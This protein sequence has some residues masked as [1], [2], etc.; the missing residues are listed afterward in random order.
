M[1]KLKKITTEYVSGNINGINVMRDNSSVITTY[2]IPRALY[3]EANELSKGKYRGLTTL[4][5]YYLVSENKKGSPIYRPN[6]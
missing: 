6:T 5:I 2:I 3:S 1:G 4:G